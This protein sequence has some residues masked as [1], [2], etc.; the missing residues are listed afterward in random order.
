M[1]RNYFRLAL[2]HLL[3]DKLHSLLNI[4]GLAVA[5]A[6]VLLI[7]AWIDDEC[8]YEKYNPNYD[9]IARVLVSY[10]PNGSG[11]FSPSTP[12]PLADELRSRYGDA[13]TRVSRSWWTQER[14][15][16]FGTK[17][18]KRTGKFMEPDGP[19]I[20]GLTMLQGSA[21]ALSDP[22][23]V[24][25]SASSAKAI[26]GNTDPIGKIV[27]IDIKMTAGVRGVYKDLPDNSEFSDVQFIGAWQLFVD[28]HDFIRDSR[29]NWGF[30]NE[31][32][33]VQLAPHADPA[34]LSARLRNCIMD[35][36]KNNKE[37]AGYHPQVAINPM[38][39]WH[40]YSAFTGNE[41]TKGLIQF[42]WLF[43]IIGGFVLIL[44]CINF[45]NL[46]TARSERR[47]KEVGIRKT[48]GSS[49]G[50]LITRFFGES[51]LMSL[52]ALIL[53][54]VLVIL[55]RPFFNTLAG[56]TIDIQWNDPRLWLAA[57]GFCILT[58]LL[59]GCYPAIYLSSF[60]PVNVLKNTLTTGRG[61]T[62]FRRTLVVLQFSVSVLL[63]VG[64]IVVFRQIDYAKDRPVGYDRQG[65]VSFL[66]K[67]PAD[68]RKLPT[69]RQEL[70]QTGAVTEMTR[71]STAATQ[72][73]DE[74]AGFSWPG[75]DPAIIGQFSTISVSP[76]YGRTIGW[77]V[78]RGRDFSAGLATDSSAVVINEG[79][80]SFMGLQHPIGARITNWSGRQYTV[81]GV[82][83]NVIA[84]SPYDQPDRQIYFLD[85]TAIPDYTWL[86]VRMKPGRS[87]PD[88]LGRI[89]TAFQSVLPNTLF[90]Y[91][92]V[93]EE[94]GKK[95]AAEE[96]IGRLAATFS[97]LAL[98]IS[99]LG[100]FGMASFMA[101]RR[102]K[103]IGIRKVLGASIPQIWQLLSKEFVALVGLSFLIAMPAAF[104]LMH[105]WLQRY[106]YH[107]GIPWWIFAATATGVL[108]VTLLTISAQSIRAALANP[109]NSLRSE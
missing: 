109:V 87:V 4:A 14:V 82:V 19:K 100:I 96:R 43:G 64:T 24:F 89:R 3:R 98:L 105:Q 17:Q 62:T 92:F 28:T 102:T 11:F 55:A 7:A 51:L 103:E 33:Y 86:L 50:R 91:Q 94:Y 101:E 84:G 6:T 35:H 107:T 18:L 44:A 34:Q 71:S 5:M 54:L 16:A 90:D 13:F 97:L 76:G 77:K 40:L 45:M 58:A 36:L 106:P 63:I 70:L 75:K 2:R 59:A 95:F 29:D 93:D 72:Y 10:S 108:I 66:L 81:I 83:N 42:V 38:P 1:L 37:A 57:I 27:T 31:E 99:G 52:L 78:T 47:A 48:I 8:S 9:R 67:N 22:G 23:S 12:Y 74:L 85:D 88:A 60:R 41:S 25:L 49:R 39:R 46:S 15:L 68:I 65:L 32:T 20:L 69:L 56:K 104:Y 61:S 26:F 21:N 79:A 73:G 30:D 80:V 53:A